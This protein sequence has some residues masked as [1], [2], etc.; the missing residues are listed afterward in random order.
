MPATA[1]VPSDAADKEF[2]KLKRLISPFALRQLKR[3]LQ[4]AKAESYDNGEACTGA[5]TLKYGL[6]C[7]HFLHHRIQQQVTAEDDP[8]A[9]YY[10]N[11]AQAEQDSVRAAASQAS[12]APKK[13]TVKRTVT[14]KV[15]EEII[16]EEI[17]EEGME[18][19]SFMTRV[20]AMLQASLAPLQQQ[21][22]ELE[23]CN[24]KNAIEISSD[25]DSDDESNEEENRESD[26]DFPVPDQVEMDE[27]DEAEPVAS[28]YGTC[29]KIPRV[30][31]LLGRGC[32]GGC[33]RGRGKGPGRGK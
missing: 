5:Y 20:Q 24:Q 19:P 10:L 22:A 6:P 25:K 8:K 27:E 9:I 16:E 12:Q 32:G 15:R 31:E 13:C 23:G 1:S 7:K 4:L 29:S 28:N 30:Q 21:V 14:K 18:E 33:G 17:E 11:L 26:D 2:E 3:Q